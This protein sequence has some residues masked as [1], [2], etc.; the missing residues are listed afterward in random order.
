MSLSA[1]RL[2][3]RLRPDRRPRGGEYWERQGQAR[4][5]RANGAIRTHQRHDQQSLIR[6]AVKRDM[7]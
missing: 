5:G 4:R 2:R 7:R 3:C 6:I 1:K